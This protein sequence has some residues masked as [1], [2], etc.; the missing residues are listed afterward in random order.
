LQTLRPGCEV[1]SG[2]NGAFPAC[3]WRVVCRDNACHC[4][5]M[6]VFTPSHAI[7]SHVQQRLSRLTVQVLYCNAPPMLPCTITSCCCSRN[8]Q[9]SNNSCNSSSSSTITHSSA[10]CVCRTQTAASPPPPPPPHPLLTS[11]RRTSPSNSNGS[12]AD[13][14][15]E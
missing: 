3:M 14:Y 12:N 9:T 10:A 8:K 13:L 15:R 1:H 11:S 7:A 6:Q 2:G 5:E 4:S